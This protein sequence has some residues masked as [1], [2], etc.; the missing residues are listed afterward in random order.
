MQAH[1]YKKLVEDFGQDK[2]DEMVDRLEE[3]ADINPKRFNGYA[4][5]ATV[6][7]KW[8]R[9]ETEKNGQVS[10]TKNIELAT[11]FKEKNNI[12]FRR[13]EAALEKDA[14]AFTYGSFYLRLPFS[15][16]NFKTRLIEQLIKMRLSTSW[17]K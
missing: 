9:E 2:T 7:R 15:D 14:L 6:I 12:L 1:H 5:H 8:I 4:N 13:N 16:K 17:I 3:Y 11:I 10:P